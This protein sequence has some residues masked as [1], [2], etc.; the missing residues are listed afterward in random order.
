MPMSNINFDLYMWLDLS[1]IWTNLLWTKSLFTIQNVSKES[2]IILRLSYTSR[3]SKFLQSVILIS[4][5]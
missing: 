5:N 1:V 2:I 4:E 3:T